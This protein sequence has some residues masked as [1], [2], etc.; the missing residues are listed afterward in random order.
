MADPV[1]RKKK[2]RTPASPLRGEIVNLPNALTMGRVAVIPFVIWLLA[3]SDELAHGEWEARRAA[4]FATVLFAGASITD[5]LDGWLARTL[6]LHSAFGRFLDP[7]ADK[8]LVLACL[9]QLVALNRVPVWLTV[10]LLSRE[11]A[12]TGLRA[13]AAEE[14]FE[15]LSDRWGKWKTALQMVGLV[16]L[17]LHFPIHSD[18]VLFGGVVDYNRT[19]LVLLGLSMVFSVVSAL[20]Y[21]AAFIRT[22]MGR[23]RQRVTALAKGEEPVSPDAAAT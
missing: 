3:Q 12:I 5:F 10:L 7:L 18:F 9:V 1:R 23:Y 13:I 2:K 19:G 8:L 17:L 15:V 22:A 4:F 20:G 11:V 21:F 16:G 14:G 6:N